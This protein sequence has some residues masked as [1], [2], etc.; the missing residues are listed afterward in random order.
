MA[1][2]DVVLEVTGSVVTS[3]SSVRTLTSAGALTSNSVQNSHLAGGTTVVPASVPNGIQFT[4]AVINTSVTYPG[5]GPIVM[6]ETV[7]DSTKKYTI[8]ITET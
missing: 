3:D 5:S 6:P 4:D 8:T 2:G 7:F 1:S